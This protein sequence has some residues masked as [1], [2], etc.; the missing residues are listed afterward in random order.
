MKFRLFFGG[1]VAAGALAVQAGEM[2]RPKAIM[3]MLDGLRADAIESAEMPNVAKLRDGTWQSGYR[4]LWSLTGRTVPDAMPSSA[5]NHVTLA[6]GVVAAKHGVV[7][8]GQTKNGHYDRWPTWLARVV[9]SRPDTKA[10]YAFSWSENKDLGVHPKVRFLE[11]S[12]EANATSL[13]K[14]MAVPDAPDAVLYFID[15]PDHFGHMTGFYPHGNGY[16][17]AL[18]QADA[19]V[20]AVLDAIAS[21]PSF[22]DEDWLVAV[23]GDHGGY[24]YAHGMWGGHA[25]TVPLVAAGRRLEQ[26]RIP[27]SPHHYDLT[28][29]I[30]AH[31][32][33]DVAALELDGQVLGNAAPPVEERPLKDGLVAFLP[34]AEGVTNLIAGGPAAKLFGAAKRIDRGFIDAALHLSGGSNVVGG[35]RLEGSERLTYGPGGSF[36]VTLWARLPKDQ[37]GD[38]A[39]FGNKSWNLG[40]N[41]GLVLTAARTTP[42]AVFAKSGFPYRGVSFNCGTS[43]ETKRLDLGTFHFTPNAWTFYAVTRSAE[44]V[45]T[46]YHGDADGRFNW[47]ADDG[48]RMTLESGL[49]FCLGQDGTGCYRFGL[50]GDIDD[51]ALWTRSLE[52][53]D[54]RRIFEA[55]RKGLGLADLL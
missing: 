1:I 15:L 50:E 12:D 26:G 9:E 5:P 2:R 8:N 7:R 41:P 23:T 43:G 11:Q 28:A 22:K 49:P 13:P 29:T 55:G 39:I 18:H 25:S 14:I 33:L 19:Y 17:H 38:P 16:L 31:F 4:G 53:E 6:T 35:V 34:F 30:L 20:G 51:F 37:T 45:V 44:G 32:G 24:T 48:S 10:L 46:F 40:V 36:A 54:V 52:P 42:T 21:R 3:F 47:I 27:A